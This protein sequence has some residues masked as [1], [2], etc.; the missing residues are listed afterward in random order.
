MAEAAA[1]AAEAEDPQLE[2][3][4]EDLRSMWELPIVVHF[5]QVFRMQFKL[6]KFGPEVRARGV[7][8]Y[9]GSRSRGLCDREL[10]VART[11]LPPRRNWRPP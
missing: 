6:S 4:R 10:T 1:G 3:M 11:P 2:E 8:S 5:A 7:L 9:S